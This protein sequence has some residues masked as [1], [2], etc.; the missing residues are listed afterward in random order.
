MTLQLF[1]GDDGLWSHVLDDPKTNM[2]L[3]QSVLIR[4]K[5]GQT[6]KA[7]ITKKSVWN[8]F[9]VPK[10]MFEPQVRGL[11]WHGQVTIMALKDDANVVVG[12]YKWEAA[13]PVSG[14][15]S[16]TTETKNHQ[17]ECP[18]ILVDFKPVALPSGQSTVMSQGA[19]SWQMVGSAPVE[20]TRTNVTREEQTNVNGP[21]PSPTDVALADVKAGLP[22]LRLPRRPTSP[23]L[24]STLRMTS[25]SMTRSVKLVVWVVTRHPG[26]F[27]TNQ[28]R[29]TWQR[30]A[31]CPHLWP[32][33]LATSTLWTSTHWWLGLWWTCGCLSGS[34]SLLKSTS[35]SDNC[36]KV[37][38]WVEKPLSMA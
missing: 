11:L 3:N 16:L 20:D 5:A 24:S 21:R 25:T 19:K 37:L 31:V 28:P 1:C 4:A 2:P 30:Q 8:N 10:P 27:C 14:A 6:L 9:F 36:H 34:H 26:A 17:D 35:Q 22:H 23:T 12:S 18:V 29:R 7:S 15:W 32:R 13:E 38:H 33:K